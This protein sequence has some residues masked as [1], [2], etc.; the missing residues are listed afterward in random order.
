MDAAES[1][2][3]ECARQAHGGNRKAPLLT[4]RTAKVTRPCS[5]GWSRPGR[6]R[7]GTSGCRRR[8]PRPRTWP[9][10]A[11][12]PP[13]PRPPPRPPHP[14]GTPAPR[15]SSLGCAA[16]PAP[17]W[18]WRGP[19]LPG[20]SSPR[21][22]AACA[23]HGLTCMR[24]YCLEHGM[25]LG[26]QWWSD[27]GRQPGAGPEHASQSVWW[28]AAGPH[29]G[30]A[31]GVM[32]R[33]LAAPVG[34]VGSSPLRSI[35]TS[36]PSS[37]CA[38]RRQWGPVAREAGPQQRAGPLMATVDGSCRWHITGDMSVCLWQA[39]ARKRF[40]GA[41]S[42]RLRRLRRC[43]LLGAACQATAPRL[44]A[45]TQRAGAHLGRLVRALPL[46]RRRAGWG[47]LGLRCSFAFGL[48]LGRRLAAL[49]PLLRAARSIS[50][51]QAGAGQRSGQQAGKG[52]STSDKQGNSGQAKLHA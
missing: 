10:A 2:S 37:S 26:L 9:P 33:F 40:S 11:P 46:G 25:R 4:R 41:P 30:A 35:T 50:G 47:R 45:S 51:L 7:A 21:R 38:A 31:A 18:R 20:S 44:A 28:R 3:A 17:C 14:P 34:G 39:C 22:R 49:C 15:P 36:C 23:P 6:C 48:R 12:R 24:C 27:A 29:A 5:P 1:W 32:R 52:R 43:V 16:W 8:P 19:S 13:R 42:Q